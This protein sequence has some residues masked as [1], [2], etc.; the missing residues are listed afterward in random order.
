MKFLTL[1]VAT[2]WCSV[3]FAQQM[4][5]T[6]G[7]RAKCDNM[8]FTLQSSLQKVADKTLKIETRESRVSQILELFMGDGEPYK[9]PNTGIL[10][11]VKMQISFQVNGKKTFLE[12]T[13]K[14]Y[15]KNLIKLA[16]DKYSKIEITQAQT[17]H[18]SSIQKV[19]D[20]YE[21][22]VTIFQ[23]FRG[24]TQSEGKDKLTYSDV[25]SKSFKCYIY[26]EIVPESG[27]YWAIK[28]GDISCDE[29]H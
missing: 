7:F 3:L 2:I 18:I 26:K 23:V 22:T 24:Y 9:D 16:N 1:F 19:N 20:H 29:V 12:R 17:H 10:K 25:Q 15:L 4:P 13:V 21:A 14:Q 8:V 6:A 11:T 27:Y 5:D 28:F